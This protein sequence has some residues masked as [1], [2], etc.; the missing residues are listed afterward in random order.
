MG[1]EFDSRLLMGT[2]V[3][4]DGIHKAVLYD[5]S[6]ENEIVKY[7]RKSGQIVWK[8]D[9]SKFPQE[10]LNLYLEDMNT[11]IESDYAASVQIINNDFYRY[12]E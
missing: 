3:F 9:E 7:N 10:E 2:D 5:L 12:I 1:I 6:F 11:L 8:I 4:S